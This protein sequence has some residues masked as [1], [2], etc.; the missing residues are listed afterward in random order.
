M[1]KRIMKVATSLTPDYLLE[2]AKLVHEND[3]PTEQHGEVL[4]DIEQAPSPARY[5]VY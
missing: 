5:K 1:L 4:E 3:E 2:A